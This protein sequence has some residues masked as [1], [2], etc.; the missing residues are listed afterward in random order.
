MAAAKPLTWQDLKQRPPGARPV[1]MGHRG[2]PDEAPENSFA[3]FALALQQGADVLETDLRFT[4][5]DEIVL[6]H[7]AT[8]DRTTDGTG[9]VSELTWAE[10]AKLRVRRPGAT[11]EGAERVPTLAAFLE[12]TRSGVPVA[13]E[14]KDLRFERDG[15]ARR[16]VRELEQHRALSRAVILSFHLSILQRFKALAP[17]LPTG[18]ITL[19]NALPLPPTDLLGPF[20]PLVYLNPLYVWWARRLGKLVGVLDPTPEPRLGYYRRL[21]VPVV[22][23]NHPGITAQALARLYR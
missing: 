16:L 7:D 19:S 23:T 5:D 11:P 8:V 14:L 13:L 12:F 21:G 22:L 2:S 6:M 9:A 17:D 18:L 20:W 3:S 4:R 10:L 15:D 1:I